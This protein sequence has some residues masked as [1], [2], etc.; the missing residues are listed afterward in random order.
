MRPSLAFPRGSLLA[1]SL[2]LLIPLGACSDKTPQPASEAAAKQPEATPSETTTATPA[3]PTP[4]TTAEPA[5][6]SAQEPVLDEPELAEA[7]GEPAP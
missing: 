6:D 2:A 4:R 5:A 7:E 1:S 3:E